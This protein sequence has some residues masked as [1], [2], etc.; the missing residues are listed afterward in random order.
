MSQ[1][2]VLEYWQDDGWY[3]GRLKGLP[4]VFSQGRTLDELEGNIQDAYR[5]MIEEEGAAPQGAQTKPVIIN[6]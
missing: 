2:F 3:V 6:A 1:T 4:G 5:L